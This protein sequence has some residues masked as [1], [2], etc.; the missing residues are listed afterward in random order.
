MKL[1]LAYS[2]LLV[3]AMTAT[4]FGQEGKKGG[5]DD[6][7]M[8]DMSGKKGMSLSMVSFRSSGRHKGIWSL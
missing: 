8:A 4:T 3:A 6:G 5:G 2:A 7:G 1:N